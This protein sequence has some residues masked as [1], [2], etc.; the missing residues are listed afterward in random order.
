MKQEMPYLLRKNGMWYA[1][2]NAGYTARAELAEIYTKEK[3]TKYAEQSGGEVAAVPLNEIIK[4]AKDVQ[5]Y[6]D[7]LEI[8]RDALA[9]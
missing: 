1:H 2:N 5:A 7:R 6:I 4:S 3:A 9:A 8:M